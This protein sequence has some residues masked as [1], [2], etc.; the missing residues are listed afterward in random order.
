MQNETAIIYISKLNNPFLD[1]ATQ[2]EI[3][4]YFCNQRNWKINNIIKEI[5]SSHR[6]LEEFVENKIES[7]EI[8]KEFLVIVN[9]CSLGENL[10]EIIGFIKKL[11]DYDIKLYSLFDPFDL[12]KFTEDSLQTS[13]ITLGVGYGIHSEKFW[14]EYTDHKKNKL[15]SAINFSKN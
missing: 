9:I 12:R 14:K 2:E 11:L 10:H 13:F 15:L 7:Q 3:L 8:N 6:L 4:K 5:D 1:V